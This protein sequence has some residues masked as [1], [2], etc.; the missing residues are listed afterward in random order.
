MNPALSSH[1]LCTEG[2]MLHS[3]LCCMTSRV[4][5]EL[6]AFSWAQKY[7]L[8][9]VEWTFISKMIIF[10]QTWANNST[11]LR[12]SSKTLH[13]GNY[14]CMNLWKSRPSYSTRV[15]VEY[16]YFRQIC[17]ILIFNSIFHSGPSNSTMIHQFY[18]SASTQLRSL[19]FSIRL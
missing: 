4:K 8:W 1:F 3:C 17:W 12:Y 18:Y 6:S 11:P 7:W 16:L 5:D 13:F 15:Q 10:V 14:L 2:R 9:K 19:T